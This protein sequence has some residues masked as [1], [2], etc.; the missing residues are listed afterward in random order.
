MPTVSEG[1][2]STL[3]A[4]AVGRQKRQTRFIGHYPGYR[5]AKKAANLRATRRTGSQAQSTITPAPSLAPQAPSGSTVVFD[6]PSESDTPYIPPDSQIAAGPSYVVAVINSLMAIYDKTGLQQ[7]GF[8]QLSAFFSSLGVNGEIFDP[9]ILYDQTDN[10]F[11]LSAAEVDMTN[12]TNGH[13][14]IAVSQTSDPRGIWHKFAINFMG[15]NLSNTANTF[16]DFPTL[17]LSSSA[18]YIS[19]GQFVLNS[20]CQANDTCSF[21]DTWIKVIGLPALLAGN[22]TLNV[23]TFTDVTTAAGEPA[24]SIEPAVTYGSAPGEFLVGADFTSNPGNNL[25]V[26]EINTS[27]TPTLSTVNLTVPSFSIP[28]DAAQPGTGFQ[29]ATN[30]FR[31]LNAVWSNNSLW[32]G[33]NVAQSAGTGAAARWYQIDTSSLGTIALAQTGDIAG[34]GDGYYPALSADPAGDLGLVFTTSSLTQY[35]SAAFTGRATSDPPNTTRTSA[36][37]RAGTSGYTDFAIRWG[38]YSGISLDPDG[39]G[40]W[41]I[42]E[43]AGQ[44]NPHF[45]TAIAQTAG[46]PSL[47][48]STTVLDFGPETVNIP[49]APL[50]VTITN[51]DARPLSLG[52]AT[53]SGSTASVFAIS[54]DGCSNVTLAAGA[55]CTLSLT[56]TPVSI[57]AASAFLEINTSP[58]ELPQL[59]Y[60]TGVGAQATA[61]LNLSPTT[62]TFPNTPA[63]TSSAPQVVNVTNTSSNPESLKIFF[64]QNNPPFTQT[65]NCGSSLGVGQTCQ[66]SLVFRPSSVSDFNGT[67]SSDLEVTY[68]GF[69][70]GVSS[71]TVAVYGTSI[72]APLTTLCPTSVNFGT[73][74][75][76][77]SSPPQAV[78]LN[79]SGTSDLTVSAV[80]ISGDFAQTNTCG[81]LPAGM[82]CTVS[83]TFS[84]TTSGTRTGTLTVTDNATAN[85]QTVQLTGTGVVSAARFLLP[86]QKLSPLAT[87]WSPQIRQSSSAVLGSSIRPF[88]SPQPSAADYG[89]LPL[90]FE[91]NNGQADSRVKFLSRGAGYMLFLTDNEAV[92]KL[93]NNNRQSRT[94]YSTSH[95]RTGERRLPLGSDIIRMAVGDAATTPHIT[96]RDRLPGK[97]NYLVGNDPSKWRTNIPLYAE[98]DYHDVYPGVDL[99]YYGNQRRLEYDFVLAPG[100]NP[101]AI[102]FRIEAPATVHG[103]TAPVSHLRVAANGDLVIP[104]AGGEVRFRRPVVYQPE[105]SRPSDPNASDSGARGTSVK[106]D[107]LKGSFILRKWRHKGY[108]VAFKIAPYDPAR[109]LVIDPVLSYSTYLGGGEKD[110]ANAIAV[111]AAGSAYI[112]GTTASADFPVANALQAKINRS[113]PSG[114]DAFITKLS[115][116]GASL[117][118]ST[119]LGGTRSEIASAIAVDSQGNAYVAGE[120][121]SS[122]FPATNGAFQTVSKGGTDGSDGF[123]AKIDSTGSSLVYSTYFGGSGNDMVT[124]IALDASADAYIAGFTAS[125][126]LPTTPGVVQRGLGGT[127]VSGG[128]AFVAE[129]NPQGTGLVYSTYLGGTEY[130][131]ATSIAVDSTGSAYV[132]GATGSLD[133][134][135]TPGAY[136]GWLSGDGR[137]A[138]ITKINPLGTGLAYSTYL[139]A[140]GN[141]TTGGPGE[142]ANGIAV[143]SQGDA[144]VAGVTNSTDFP[145]VNPIQTGR[146]VWPSVTQ[147][148]VTKLHPAGCGLVYSTRLGGFLYTSGIGIA[149]DSGGDAYV[150][151]WTADFDFPVLNP[152]QASYRQVASGGALHTEAFIS[153]LAPSGSSLLYSSYLG[154]TTTDLP[155]GYGGGDSGKAIAVDSAGNPYIAGEADSTDFPVV[156]GADSVYHGSRDGFVTKVAP[157]IVPSIA[158]APSFVVFP[159]TAVGTTSAPVSIT[160]TNTTSTPVAISSVMARVG[161][162]TFGVANNSCNTTLQ[163]GA[164]CKFSVTFSP[165]LNL[166]DS[167]LV[168]VNDNA[169]AGPHSVPLYGT[170][171]TPATIKILGNQS[172]SEYLATPAGTPVTYQIP[173]ENTGNQPLTITGV[174]VGGKDFSQTNDCTSPQRFQ[175]FC[176]VNLTF[177]PTAGG[178]ETGTLT[179]TGN[180]DNSPQTLPLTGVGQD[181]AMGATPGTSS[182]ATVT[183]GQMATFSVDVSSTNGFNQFI[184]LACSGAPA[185]ATCSLDQTGITIYGTTPVTAKITVRTAAR[186]LLPNGRRLDGPRGF[187]PAGWELLFGLLLVL[188]ATM[189]VVSAPAPPVASVGP[190][191]RSLLRVSAIILLVLL[192]ATCGGGGGGGGGGGPSQQTGTP[193]G[194]YTLTVTGSYGSL[195]R[196]TTLKLTVQ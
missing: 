111:D 78:S 164:S 25:N 125:T 72:A 4:A 117:V 17:G 5:A 174:T 76:G 64:R 74:T 105:H 142:I 187:H 89:K 138:F 151:G 85:R 130:D 175:Q 132:A 93:Q 109:P 152:F 41:M 26:F 36:I 102:R 159:D 53:I 101:K 58:A 128:D 143:D 134:P 54:S 169:F 75:V 11:I 44:P 103:Q 99:I 136:Q 94:R 137:N 95:L 193:A 56:F 185:R 79:N 116:D 83:V 124:S 123:L 6:G 107:Y 40:F 32:C 173:V 14:L 30:D 9:R 168:T 27:G 57:G 92:L 67:Y 50:P 146:P 181:F 161:N 86:L 16:P 156:N 38:D 131:N 55:S 10:R 153:E 29:I 120:T 65:N 87:R 182:S 96:G 22:S 119:F 51:T 61:G 195:N 177:A 42:A 147:A 165:T 24:F 13:V 3:A 188:A 162:P 176:Y 126:D 18:V 170:G 2:N 84:P 68:E 39:S 145:T 91:A 63:H 190:R 12:L 35:A 104:T 52:A 167:S 77:T 46:P 59:V 148:F 144:Y 183:A 33:Q 8:Q 1:W 141:G 158:L 60:L 121:T 80:N 28:P 192:W 81:T 45:G 189:T 184:S 118:Y 97:L 73:Q 133:F 21:S 62:I 100:A 70:T 149:V 113:L 7:G 180:A 31:L 191:R 122:D 34:S 166:L 20:A 186:S 172:N 110:E 37:Y 47:G 69:P 82:G 155:F 139:G 150:T 160:I 154:G 98:V 49:S 135:T 15:R 129:V 71:P 23:T 112:A 163:A 194:I 106:R 108:E 127:P 48:L 114:T 179:V 66:I 178:T 140:S 115:P 90:A 171:Y 196:S 19:S 43:Y 88:R 157:T